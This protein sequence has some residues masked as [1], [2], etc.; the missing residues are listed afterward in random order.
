MQAEIAA[1]P[2]ERTLAERIKAGEAACAW[3]G[4]KAIAEGTV[5][6]AV[7]TNK[8]LKRRA[9]MAP[10]CAKHQAMLEFEEQRTS[11]LKDIAKGE[12]QV[13]KTDAESRAGRKAARNLEADRKSLERLLASRP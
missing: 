11:L 9:I 3:C 12:R 6:P 2:R 1:L 5:E 10:V 4:E 8:V 13:E 7:V